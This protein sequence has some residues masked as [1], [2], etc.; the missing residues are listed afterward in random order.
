M[1][2]NRKDYKET[3]IKEI[4]DIFDEGKREYRKK[5]HQKEGKVL[6]S[7][8]LVEL[9]FLEKMTYQQISEKY[10]LSPQRIRQLII[11][12]ERKINRYGLIKEAP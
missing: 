8:D 4:C 7:F 9:R 2:I 6:S 1:I 5:Y 10:D 3:S 11:R 12:L